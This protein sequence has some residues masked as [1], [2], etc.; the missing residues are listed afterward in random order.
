M[1]VAF[2]EISMSKA[3]F[4]RLATA[5]YVQGRRALERYSAS[6]SVARLGM[7]PLAFHGNFLDG[8]CFIE[9]D[10]KYVICD[11]ARQS[12]I[13]HINAVLIFITP[14]RLQ[15]QEA[16]NLFG[17]GGCSGQIRLPISGVQLFEVVRD[18]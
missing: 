6:K 9:S 10:A 17:F 13:E 14:V 16:K 3:A 7:L 1:T 18:E 12:E 11:F 8:T 5:N 4:G 15:F 2:S